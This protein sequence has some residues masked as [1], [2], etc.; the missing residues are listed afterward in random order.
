MVKAIIFDLQGTLV[1][2]G[3]YPSP[4][5]QIKNI[6]RIDAPFSDFVMRFEKV[7]MIGQYT[8][9]KDAFSNVCEEFHL[10]P[11]DYLIEKMVGL[12]NKNKL[13]SQLYP[14]TIPTLTDLKSEYKLILVANIDSLSKD[15]VTKFSL[16]K[17]FDLILLSCDTGLLKN[18]KGFYD[19]IIDTFNLEP[20][21]MLMVGDSLESD[22]D[23]AKALG[24]KG[25]LVDR[26]NKREYLPKIV[27]L[28][29]L[30]NYLD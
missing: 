15:M 11:R 14:D 5:R 27:A 9:L 21:D 6:L 2:K 7:L 1:E 26:H 25:V 30:R 16:E 4:L 17:Y 29:E 18:E 19:V 20:E 8:S 22:I 28:S 10:Q 23:T 3:V 24:I 12:W 13:L